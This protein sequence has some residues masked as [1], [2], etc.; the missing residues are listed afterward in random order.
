MERVHSLP[1][2]TGSSP[3]GRK[4][5]PPEKEAS[6]TIR[7]FER[8]LVLEIAERYHHNAHR[9]LQGATPFS[10]WAAAGRKTPQQ[11]SRR[12]GHGWQGERL[13]TAE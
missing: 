5:R 12:G 2:S 9:G 3:E 6:L 7:E 11:S 4:A 1:G 13:P 10:E 8:W